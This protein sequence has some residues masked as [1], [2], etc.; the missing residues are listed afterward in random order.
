M[1][2]VLKSELYRLGTIRSWWLSVLGAGVLTTAVTLLGDAAWAVVLG[3]AVF[4]FGVVFGTQHYQHR[5][6]V[7]MFLAQPRRVRAL[8]GQTLVFAF[9]A[10]AFA[11]V[12]GVPMLAVEPQSYVT[13]VVVTPFLAIFAVANAAILRRPIFIL[14][15][16]GGWFFVVEVLLGRLELPGPFTAFLNTAARAQPMMLIPAVFWAMVAA[17]VASWA[18]RRDVAGE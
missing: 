4:G 10:T 11:V 2:S 9:G 15:G 5:T 6:A 13:T 12:T 14:A 3:M 1:I 17:A 7:L 18:V 8:V 16:Y